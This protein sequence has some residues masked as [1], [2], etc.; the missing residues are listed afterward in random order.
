MSVQN[1]IRIM[2]CLLPRLIDR[3]EHA[4]KL[5]HSNPEE[6]STVEPSYTGQAAWIFSTIIRLFECTIRCGRVRWIEYYSSLVFSSFVFDTAS[7]VQ[8]Y[9]ANKWEARKSICKIIIRDALWKEYWF[10]LHLYCCF[11]FLPFLPA[12]ILMITPHWSL[13]VILLIA[14]S[15]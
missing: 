6:L 9:W 3:R 10:Y 12:S 8:N 2:E 13:S 7:E 15:P 14:A 4:L 1:T 5:Y 11:P